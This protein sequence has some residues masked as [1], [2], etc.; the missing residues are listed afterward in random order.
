MIGNKGIDERS[1]ISK[2]SKEELNIQVVIFDIGL[3]I[4]AKIGNETLYRID[5][6]K[7]RLNG[8]FF[9]VKEYPRYP[10][11]FSDQ[12]LLQYCVPKYFLQRPP[13]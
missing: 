2:S 4:L 9:L 6:T 5:A 12:S 3:P 8:L 1:I 13:R 10:S 11:L 7:E